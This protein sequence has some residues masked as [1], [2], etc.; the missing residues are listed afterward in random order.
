MT[1]QIILIDRGRVLAE[2]N[3]AEIRDK[4][5]EHPTTVAMVSP[6]PRGL[7]RFLIG[8][9]HVVSVEIDIEDRVVVKT[10]HAITFYRVL[11]S[12]ILENNLLVEEILTLDDSLEAVFEYLTQ[13]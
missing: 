1:S 6:D 11:P 3:V 12:W 2:G 7:A 5:E 4:I 10:D 13:H 8:R 9:E